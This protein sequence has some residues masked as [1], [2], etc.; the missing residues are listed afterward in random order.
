LAV[1]NVAKL[2]YSEQKKLS[3]KK[4][5]WGVALD[6]YRKKKR[7]SFKNT[8]AGGHRQMRPRRPRAIK[9][10]PCIGQKRPV[11][12]KRDPCVRQ[13]RA[14]YKAKETMCLCNAGYTG[15]V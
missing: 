2:F 12:G 8:C 6:F 4:V 14:M 7:G 5:S 10:D 15:D 11:T 3:K 9:R 13:K 1:N